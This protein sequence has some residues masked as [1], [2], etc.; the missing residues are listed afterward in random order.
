MIN[1]IKSFKI[2]LIVVF[3]STSCNNTQPNMDQVFD[4]YGKI[5]G[6][7]PSL[8]SNDL[9]FILRPISG[10]LSCYIALL[11]AIT[12]MD[13]HTSQDPLIIFVGNP[14][15][16]PPGDLFR[17]NEKFGNNKVFI[18]STDILRTYNLNALSSGFFHKTKMGPLR[19]EYFYKDSEPKLDSLLLAL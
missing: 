14:I 19:F 11:D 4:E 18:D 3:F 6:I 16:F 12:T 5:S 8:S 13:Q 17:V 10:C 1:L 7:H 2:F 15:D 9:V